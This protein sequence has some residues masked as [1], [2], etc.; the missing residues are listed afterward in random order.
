METNNTEPVVNLPSKVSKRRNHFWWQIPL[1]VLLFGGGWI[2]SLYMQESELKAATEDEKQL[3]EFI[4]NLDDELTM[5]VTEETFEDELTPAEENAAAENQG[6]AETVGAMAPRNPEQARETRLIRKFEIPPSPTLE[7]YRGNDATE[8]PGFDWSDAA[9]SLPPPGATWET[10]SWYLN[11]EARSRITMID[12]GG[13]APA[14][15]SRLEKGEFIVWREPKPGF[16]YDAIKGCGLA[17]YPIEYMWEAIH[18]AGDSSAVTDQI[19]TPPVYVKNRYLWESRDID[20]GPLG[21]IQ[22][23]V[24]VENHL[25]IWLETWQQEGDSVLLAMEGAWR[26]YPVGN[27]TFLTYYQF[28][29]PPIP[30]PEKLFYDEN[31]NVAQKLWTL[32][33]A[34]A[35]KRIAEFPVPEIPEALQPELEVITVTEEDSMV[36]ESVTTSEEPEEEIVFESFDPARI[37]EGV[38]RV[39]DQGEVALWRRDTNDGSIRIAGCLIVDK[40]PEETF[41]WIRGTPGIPVEGELANMLQGAQEELT[42]LVPLRLKTYS[43]AVSVSSGAD[44]RAV[45]SGGGEDFREISGFWRCFRLEENKTFVQ[46]DAV[47]RPRVQSASELLAPKIF[48][49][50]LE[51][52]KATLV[53]TEDA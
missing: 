13:I 2:A 48:Q 3:S 50:C 7:A 39:I 34:Y 36:V 37:P 43:G 53:Q 26:L 30:L 16:N 12:L 1:I 49:L 23:R 42:F 51:R 24:R 31:H 41:R 11:F 8:G 46:Y 32:V 44:G 21:R 25:E 52:I 6:P 20:F 17:N 14:L 47:F 4:D 22:I 33:N 15:R 38:R 45:W 29:A 19:R 9:H 18:I 5:I 10:E 40:A 27:R 28:A 35:E